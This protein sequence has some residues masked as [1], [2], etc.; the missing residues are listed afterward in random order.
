[1]PDWLEE[2][3]KQLLLP[4]GWQ[5]ELGPEQRVLQKQRGRPGHPEDTGANGLFHLGAI[6]KRLKCLVLKSTP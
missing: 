5:E 1:M 6:K 4:L 3:P 2:V